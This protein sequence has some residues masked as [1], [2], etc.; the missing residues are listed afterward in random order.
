[1][2]GQPTQQLNSCD[3]VWEVSSTSSASLHAPESDIDD[4]LDAGE[5]AVDEPV[6]PAF[7]IQ[8]DNASTSE[9]SVDGM[10]TSSVTDLASTVAA[11]TQVIR[12][13]Q[14]V[15]SDRQSV[16]R[17]GLLRQGFSELNIAA[18]FNKYSDG[19]HSLND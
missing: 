10:D 14:L 8:R 4:G 7:T 9:E 19:T 13:T 1:T 12:E 5:G 16:I 18:Y 3:L 15:V 11:T 17:D 2:F 6:A